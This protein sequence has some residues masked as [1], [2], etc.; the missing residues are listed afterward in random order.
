MN[1]LR[2]LTANRDTSTPI[3]CAS[4]Q[5]PE[6]SRASS[7]GLLPNE[8]LQT[9]NDDQDYTNF[10]FHFNKD[11]TFEFKKPFDVS[12][13]EGSGLSKKYLQPTTTRCGNFNFRFSKCGDVIYIFFF[14]KITV[15]FNILSF[16]N[17]KMIVRSTEVFD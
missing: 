3:E 9:P 7:F 10:S 14:M 6:N 5:Y 15:E 17:G 1:T 11:E 16:F 2:K 13:F 12:T 8:V 4:F